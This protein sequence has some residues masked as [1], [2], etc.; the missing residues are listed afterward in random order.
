[1]IMRFFIFILLFIFQQYSY[2]SYFG[3]REQTIIFDAKKKLA[4]Y[5][6]DNTD[7]K[8][9]WLVQ[10]WVENA[11]ENKTNAFVIA[12]EVF[13]VEPSSAFNVRI[14]EKETLSVEHETLFWVVSHSLPN[15]NRNDN[16]VVDDN[17][18]KAEL[19]L[20]YRFKTPM[21]YRPAAIADLQPKPQL[22][23]WS[24]GKDGKIQVYN[25][26]PHIFYLKHIYYSGKMH[27]GKGISYLIPPKKKSFIDIK[28]KNGDVFKFGVVNDFGAVKEYEG[29]VL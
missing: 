13:R 17:K 27:K 4:T 11:E 3:P 15:G 14:L 2:A 20:A 28:M 26:T 7:K 9:P 23:Q 10:A 16:K 29:T 18:V 19:N 22:L 6:I 24:T 12:P 25:P 21:I 1:M 8:D 5:H